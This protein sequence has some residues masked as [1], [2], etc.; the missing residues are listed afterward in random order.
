MSGSRSVGSAQPLKHARCARAQSD[1]RRPLPA[2]QHEYYYDRASD[3]IWTPAESAT[4]TFLRRAS[5]VDKYYAHGAGSP[6]G[7]ATG[8]VR[9]AASPAAL[10]HVQ[11]TSTSAPPQGLRQRTDRPA[12]GEPGPPRRER[13]CDA[14]LGFEYL[15]ARQEA[16]RRLFARQRHGELQMRSCRPAQTD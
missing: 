4:L 1:V 9:R 5:P 8:I 12:D 6:Y 16:L 3:W 14:R 2:L 7:K 11:L 15:P 10:A 13:Q